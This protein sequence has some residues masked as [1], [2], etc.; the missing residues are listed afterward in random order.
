MQHSDYTK[1]LPDDTGTVEQ[2]VLRVV[3]AFLLFGIT[4]F[5]LTVDFNNIETAGYLAL[6]S[7]N[8]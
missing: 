6:N 5:V 4:S 3:I 8:S 7:L 2:R 1:G